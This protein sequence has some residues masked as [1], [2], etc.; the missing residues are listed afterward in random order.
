M[1]DQPIQ[2]HC[3]RNSGLTPLGHV[4]SPEIACQNF[5]TE[6]EDGCSYTGFHPVLT[7]VSPRVLTTPYIWTKQVARD[8]P[9]GLRL[10]RKTG[11]LNGDISGYYLWKQ[12]TGN[13][14]YNHPPHITLK[15]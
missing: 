9:E 10:Q 3:C 15:S 14:S 4:K 13:V 5:S 8:S 7:G 2:G 6:E 12:D 1:Q 11:T